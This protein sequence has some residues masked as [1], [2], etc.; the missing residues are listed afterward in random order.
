MPGTIWRARLGRLAAIQER[1]KLTVGIP[2]HAELELLD[3][4]AERRQLDRRRRRRRACG[5]GRK[6]FAGQ[7]TRTLAG[8][9]GAG[10]RLV[11]VI[12]MR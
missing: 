9:G 12:F 11:I 5:S 3:P 6:C 7:R 4:Q 10:L 1:R 8:A 2:A